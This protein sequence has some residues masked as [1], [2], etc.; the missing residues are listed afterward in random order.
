MDPQPLGLTLSNK[1]KQRHGVRAGLGI[2][3]HISPQTEFVFFKLEITTPHVTYALLGVFT[4]FV[5]SYY[6]QNPLNLILQTVW[7]VLVVPSRKGT[8]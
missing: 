5:C 6:L 7:H 3:F 4:F 8:G 1:S 2:Q